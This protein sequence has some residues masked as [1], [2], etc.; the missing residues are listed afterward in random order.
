MPQTSGDNQAR[1]RGPF[2]C[3]FRLVH[4][5][6]A[7]ALM[8]SALATL[9]PEAILAPLIILALWT[10]VFARR[11]RPRGL[12]EALLLLPLL[13]CCVGPI[14]WG[15][16]PANSRRHVVSCGNNL[17]QI[18]FALQQYHDLYGEFPPAYLADKNGKPMHSWRVL[19][20]PFLLNRN[21]YDK[22]HFDE[23][24]NGPRNRQLLEEIRGDPYRCPDDPRSADDSR[25]WT[26]YV[27][28]LGPRT[29]WP[30]ARGRKLSEIPD[31]TSNTV[32]VVEDHSRRIAWME[33]RD[34]EFEEAQRLFASVDPQADGLH[35]RENFFFVFRWGRM[36]ACAD[37]SV[38]FVEHEV[39]RDDWAAL[40]TVDDG[41]KPLVLEANGPGREI[42][43]VKLGN[44]FR[45]AVFALLVILPFPWVWHTPRP[46]SKS[47]PERSG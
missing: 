41:V 14:F 36:V 26:S 29:M 28:V 30:G 6:Y 12:F 32:I 9:G 19:I 43:R 15:I 8:G 33:P 5:G 24:W 31:G 44:C 13:T 7:I 4:F 17:N 11:S 25:K 37:G 35:R 42:R 22:Y 23:P 10:Y 46:R 21:L 27:A 47:A 2:V 18:S 38:H 16:E 20:L 40:L 39:K 3:Q 1:D 34:L 45:L